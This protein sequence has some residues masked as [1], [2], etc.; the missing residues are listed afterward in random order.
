[1]QLFWQAT[2]ITPAPIFTLFQ[3]GDT[4]ILTTFI[5]GFT[6]FIH[7][8]TSVLLVNV[9]HHLFIL[10]SRTLVLFF[11]YLVF[12]AVYLTSLSSDAAMTKLEYFIYV[13]CSGLD[14]CFMSWSAKSSRFL[15]LWIWTYFHILIYMQEHAAN[16]E[17]L[18]AHCSYLFE[19]A[20]DIYLSVEN[21]WDISLFTSRKHLQDSDN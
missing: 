6:A 10:R 14:V 12:V 5:L 21:A 16:V 7:F 19:N 18:Q 4:D 11:L 3:Q 2:C 20:W 13:L 9:L 17:V 8:F 1:M 15:H